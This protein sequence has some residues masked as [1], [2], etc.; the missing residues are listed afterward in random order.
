MDSSFASDCI[1]HAKM[2]QIKQSNIVGNN[3][4]ESN[5][6]KRKENIAKFQKI[7][8]IVKEL[9]TYAKQSAQVE[10][11]SNSQSKGSIFNSRLTTQRTNDED[12]KIQMEAEKKEMYSKFPPDWMVCVQNQGKLVGFFDQA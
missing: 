1:G 10:A 3:Q 9:P 6:V 12:T 4:V 5:I 2:K 7:V 11:C 8:N